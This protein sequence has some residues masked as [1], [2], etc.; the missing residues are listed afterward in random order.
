MNQIPSIPLI[1]AT[2]RPWNERFYQLVAKDAANTLTRDERLELD[3]LCWRLEAEY[4]QE[5]DNG[6]D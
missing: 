1:V 4:E 3:V 5:N 6:T 2:V